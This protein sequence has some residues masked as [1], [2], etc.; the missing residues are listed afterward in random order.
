M[1]LKVDTCLHKTGKREPELRGQGHG[2]NAGR[3]SNCF[4]VHAPQM[5]TCSNWPP[6]V[7]KDKVFTFSKSGCYTLLRAESLQTCLTLC[8]SDSV[9]HQAPLPMWFS[10]QEH[11]E[12]V[13]MSSS[14]RSSPPRD[15]T[16][17]SSVLADGFF[18]TST[19]WEAAGLANPEY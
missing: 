10:R 1:W 3:S 4:R 5:L 11:W 2:Q 16:R 14:R 8:D 6:K 18:A 9:A 13:A 7:V 19:T 12:W 15:R 17:V